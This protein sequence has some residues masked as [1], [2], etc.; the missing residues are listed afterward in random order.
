MWLFSSAAQ[1][2]ALASNSRVHVERVTDTFWVGGNV[3][4]LIEGAVFL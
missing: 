3:T 1:G 4:P 2:D